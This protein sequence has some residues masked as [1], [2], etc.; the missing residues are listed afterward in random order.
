MAGTIS[1]GLAQREPD[2]DGLEAR[3]Q[4]AQASRASCRETKNIRVLTTGVTQNP[5]TDMSND[6]DQPLGVAHSLSSERGSA[7]KFNPAGGPS[8]LSHSTCQQSDWSCQYP[9]LKA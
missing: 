8:L 9:I 2:H 3:T 7:D 5:A 4:R 6:A 1:I